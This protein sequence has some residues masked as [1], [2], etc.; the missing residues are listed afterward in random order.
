MRK[1]WVGAI[2]AAALGMA[3]FVT[4]A[5]AADE[6]KIWVNGR[7][8]ETPE[9]APRIENGKVVAPVREIAEALGAEVKWNGERGAVE[10]SAPETDSLKQQIQ[11]LQSAV[12]AQTPE[13]AVETWV[14]GVQTRNGALQY[15]MLSKRQREL[16]LKALESVHWVTGTSSP[17][18]QQYRISEATVNDDGSRTFQVQLDYRTSTDINEPERWDQIPAFPV[19]VQK[20]DEVWRIASFPYEWAYQSAELP[21][22]QTLTDYD[23]VYE[24][25]NVRVQFQR[26]GIGPAGG[27]VREAVGNHAEIVK[28]ETIQLPVGE[29]TYMEVHRT[30]PAAA[31]SDEVTVELWLVLLRDDP[32]REDMKRT[33]CLTGIVTGELQAAYDELM[34]IASTW[35]LTEE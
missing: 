6:I 27:G 34:K 16:Q 31:Q 18:V 13:E 14:K 33:Y 32:E 7:Q 24:G 2:G 25:R 35:T 3:I 22:G 12:A 29:V 17:W 11:L 10:V 8:V 1:A 9:A 4:G 30:Q 26:L 23:G 5:Y 19:V 20:E 15:A 28:Q 21:D